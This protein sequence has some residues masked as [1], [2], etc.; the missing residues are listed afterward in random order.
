[1][2]LHVPASGCPC[3]PQCPTTLGPQ[4]AVDRKMQN[5][6]KNAEAENVCMGFTALFFPGTARFGVKIIRLLKFHLRYQ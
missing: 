3:H 5:Q 4:G 1:M 6:E 2:S